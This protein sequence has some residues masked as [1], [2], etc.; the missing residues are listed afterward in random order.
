[1]RGCL[2]F[3]TL[4]AL[5]GA[6]LAGR[7]DLSIAGQT[8]TAIPIITANDVRLEAGGGVASCRS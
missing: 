6:A 4:V 3:L 8:V 1:V 7:I 5:L 2:G